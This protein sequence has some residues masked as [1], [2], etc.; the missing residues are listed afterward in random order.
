MAKL[1]SFLFIIPVY[2]SRAQAIKDS[3]PKV[4][5]V[6][7]IALRIFKKPPPTKT[8]S[9]ALLPILGYNPSL[10]FQIGINFVGGRYLGEITNT[11]LSVFSLSASVSSKG[12]ITG[13]AR[14]NIFTANDKWNFQGNWQVTKFLTFDYGV[15]TGGEARAIHGGFTAFGIPVKNQEGVFPIKYF[16][17]RLN[18]KFYRKI[19]RGLSAGAGVSF[20]IRRNIRDEVHDSGKLSPHYLYSTVNG[21]DPTHYSLN[22]I[23]LNV[24]YITRDHPNRAYRGIYADLGIRINPEWLGSTKYSAQWSTEIRKYFSLSKINPEHVLA[25]WHWGRYGITGT[26]PYLDLPG[27][28]ADVY[29]RSGRAYTLYR[30]KG[31]SFF[32]AEAEYRFPISAN[33]LLSG[34]LFYNTETGSNQRGVKLFDYWE[35]G[36]GTGL[37]ILFNKTT[38]TNL[39]IDY[40]V[41]RNGT[42]GLFFGLNEVF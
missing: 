2:S 13:Q 11:T 28:G 31:L 15:G 42:S 14:H 18:E 39:C 23:T 40:G 34:V 20:D 21:F 26:M 10:G 22:G 37:R 24:Q 8:S 7:D 30:F 9:T 1:C 32:Y 36:Y 16:Y 17:L 41:G 25:F 38:R 35:Q 33:K 4:T 27:T 3:V 29:N 19:A 12:I 6:K 5:D